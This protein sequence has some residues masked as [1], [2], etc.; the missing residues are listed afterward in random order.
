MQLAVEFADGH[1]AYLPI[2]TIEWFEETRR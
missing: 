1:K 2:H